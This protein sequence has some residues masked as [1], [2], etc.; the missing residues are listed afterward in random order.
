MHF[1]L[2]I[3]IIILILEFF[4]TP[5]LVFFGFIFLLMLLGYMFEAFRVKPKKSDIDKHLLKVSKEEMKKLDDCFEENSKDKPIKVDNF[6]NKSPEELKEEYYTKL[7][8]EKTIQQTQEQEYEEKLVGTEKSIY[9]F[10]KLLKDYDDLSTNVDIL[11]LLIK[12]ADI[13]AKDYGEHHDSHAILWSSYYSQ[14]DDLRRLNEDYLPEVYTESI[15]E[16]KNSLHS[17]V[18]TENDT[19]ILKMMEQIIMIFAKLYKIENTTDDISVPY[20]EQVKRI[21]LYQSEL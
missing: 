21:N 9:K 14:A 8:E 4:L 11:N 6:V 16:V 17:F 2:W 7:K 10:R 1:L 3:I 12:S 18:D 19:S 15:D 20:L 5:F 13:L